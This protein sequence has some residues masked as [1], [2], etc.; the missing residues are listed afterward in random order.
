MKKMF[1][2]LILGLFISGCGTPAQRA[3]FLKHD[4][5]YKNWD[6]TKFSWSGFKNPTVETGKESQEQNWWGEPI[7]FKQQ[8]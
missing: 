2:A 6:H 5:M 4:T 7:E 3:E 1:L 8:R